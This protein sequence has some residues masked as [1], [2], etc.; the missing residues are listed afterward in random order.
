MSIVFLQETECP[1]TQIQEL[2]K[3]IWKRSEHIGI[4]ARGYAGGLGILWYP[5]RVSL[6]G[7]HGN[8]CLLSATFKVVW[9]SVE[10]MITN[11]YGPHNDGEKT[12]FIKSLRKS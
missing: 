6:G 1:T 3:K 10:G 2:S 5:I 7:F 4:N 11:V 8:K 9:F 12:E